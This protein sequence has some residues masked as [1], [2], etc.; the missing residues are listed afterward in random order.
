MLGYAKAYLIIERKL[1]IF[2]RYFYKI[3]IKNSKIK[4]LT[5]GCHKNQNRD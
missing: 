1:S 2:E 3:P 5:A 4:L